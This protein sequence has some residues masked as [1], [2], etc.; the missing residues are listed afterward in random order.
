M[1]QSIY[2]KAV[3]SYQSGNVSEAESQYK[4]VLKAQPNHILAQVSLGFLLEQQDRLSEAVSAYKRAIALHPEPN[5][6]AQTFSNLGNIFR[7]QGKSAQ[8]VK[9]YQQALKIEPNRAI[10]QFNLGQTLD[11]LGKFD[12]A[13]R[14]YQA[15][16]KANPQFAKAYLYLAAA[17]CDQDRLIAADKVCKKLLQITPHCSDALTVSGNIL[18]AQEQLTKAATIYQRAIE[19]NSNNIYAYYNLGNICHDQYDFAGAQSAFKQALAIDPTFSA[20]RMGYCFSCLPIIY[21]NANTVTETRQRYQQRL[22]A[23]ATYFQTLSTEEKAAAAAG[24]G[25]F[26]P[27]YLAYQGFSDRTLQKVYGEMIVDLMA[28]RYPQWS[29]PLERPTLQEN[30]KIRV[31]FV[32]RFFYQHSNWKIP[33]KGWVENL[34]R[35]DFELFGYYTG[36]IEDSATAAARQTFDQFIQGLGSVEQWA[37]KIKTDNLHIL[38]CPEFGMDP[39]TV[40]LGC[41]KLAP[42]QM[43]FGGHPETSGMPTIDYHLSSELMEPENGQTH[44]TEKLINLPNLAFHYTLLDQ[45]PRPRTKPEIGLKEDDIMFWCCQSLFKYLPQHDDVFPQIA[46]ALPKARFVFIKSNQSECITDVFRQRL[47]QAFKAMDLEYEHHCTFLPRMDSSTFAGTIAIADIFLDSIGWSGDNTTME[48][49]AYNL[50]IVTWPGKLMRGRHSAA[51]LKMMGIEETIAASK[52]EYVAMAIRLGQDLEYRNYISQQVAD[53]K[54][55]LY[56]DL[57]PVRA[58]ETVFLELVGKAN[59]A[60]SASVAK[61]LQA[62]IQA[63]KEQNFITA[64]QA[65]QRI[66]SQ[67]PKHPEALYGLGMIAQ[68]DQQIETAIQ[69]LEASVRS[70]PD[71]VKAWFALGNLYHEQN[72][73][74]SA[75]IAYRQALARRPDSVSILNNLGSALEKQSYWQEAIECYQSALSIQPGCLEAESNL[76]NAHHAT[77]QLPDNRR[78]HYVDINLTLMRAYYQRGHQTAALNY[79]QQALKLDPDNKTAQQFIQLTQ[80]EFS[81][82]EFTQT[83]SP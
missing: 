10:T 75:V 33:M 45:S 16:V 28:S 3:E 76:G 67:Q 12:H 63:Q 21:A 53:N 6:T 32:S 15:A 82:P 18:Q 44:Y 20:A 81:Q 74:A 71:A 31:G 49:T 13:V 43:T 27:F 19:Q 29:L 46:I 50:P 78:Q 62:A 58:L 1:I 73:F 48:S 23:L 72:R 52:A 14:A 66:L 57:Q 2:Q 77:Q 80:P 7:V 8:A 61:D 26:Q 42:T 35:V 38:I 11:Q 36:S 37:Q 4:Q 65:F 9:A 60:Q 40:K 30:E 39:M 56:K 69:C 25:T 47:D 55:K 64:K 41:L 5:I 17:L 79:C 22:T 34:N 51:M 70:Q 24:V 83:A 59:S 54:H 68:Q